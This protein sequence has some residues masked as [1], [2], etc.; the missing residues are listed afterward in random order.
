MTRSPYSTFSADEFPPA[1]AWFG[2]I[3]AEFVAAMATPEWRD[4]PP[5]SLSLLFPDSKS[6]HSNLETP[7]SKSGREKFSHPDFPP[8]GGLL[9]AAQ[10]AAR[11]NCSIKTLNAHVAAREVRY[12]IIGK[13]T[14]R[15]RRYFNVAD[16][17][18]FIAAQT[19]EALPCPSAATRAP[20]SGSTIFKSEIIAFSGLQK[21]PRSGKPKP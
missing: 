1:P 20:R 17:D 5:P 16:L 6:E 13:G 11:L 19:R 15:P 2:E 8:P 3:C 10:A 14:K 7:D 18:V 9:T 4:V 21:R 12:V